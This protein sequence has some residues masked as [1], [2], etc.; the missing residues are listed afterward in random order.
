MTGVEWVA[1]S[2]HR[3][4]LE[5]ADAQGCVMIWDQLNG[6]MVTGWK[7]NYELTRPFVTHWART[8]VGPEQQMDLTGIKATHCEPRGGTSP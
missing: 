1:L 7:N 6:L 8:V 4:E 3:P 2:D 5:D